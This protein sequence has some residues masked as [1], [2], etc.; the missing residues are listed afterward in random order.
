MADTQHWCG[1]HDQWPTIQFYNWVRQQKGS[2]YVGCE[3]EGAQGTRWRSANE[4]EGD[5][6]LELEPALSSNTATWC[7]PRTTRGTGRGSRTARQ[8]PHPRAPG[9]TWAGPPPP[10]RTCGK[11]E[12]DGN[13]QFASF[14]CILYCPISAYI[15]FSISLVPFNYYLLSRY[16]STPGTPPQLHHT[17]FALSTTLSGLFGGSQDSSSSCQTFLS[18]RK[19]PSHLALIWRQTTSMRLGAL[20]PPPQMFHC[21]KLLNGVAICN[22]VH[23]A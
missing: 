8:A 13:H 2:G 16:V 4:G 22:K 23:T 6:E 14:T 3:A 20:L 18:I 17:T 7:P 5:R 12:G 15:I 1:K 11:G 21:V 9:G 10:G 19:A